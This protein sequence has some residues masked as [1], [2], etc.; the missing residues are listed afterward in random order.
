MNDFESYD[1]F[2]EFINDFALYQKKE[3]FNIPELVEG[4]ENTYA[5][6]CHLPPN[7][8]WNENIY[9]QAHV[10]W[11]QLTGGL[12]GTGSGSKVVFCCKSKVHE[13]ILNLPTHFKYITIL[14]VG[15]NFENSAIKTP[16]S[17]FFVTLQNLT[18]L[19]SE[20]S[21]FIV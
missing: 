21:L 20:W 9:H 3:R 5:Y 18:E 11:N 7:I 1:D 10:T 8:E 14:R 19:H 12:T 17:Y 4:E 13:T 15:M 16:I 2:C 6:I